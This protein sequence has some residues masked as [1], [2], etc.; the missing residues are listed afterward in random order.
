MGARATIR[1]RFWVEAVFAVLATG[2]M[3]LTMVSREWIEWL[4]GTDPDGGSGTL[5]WVIVAAWAAVAM[6]AGLLA[7]H[8]WRRPVNQPERPAARSATL[9]ALLWLAAR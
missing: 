8:E 9:K 1:A 3:L 4:T 7:R 2:L 5:E 6:V